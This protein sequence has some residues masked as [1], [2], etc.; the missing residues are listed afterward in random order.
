MWIISKIVC[1]S[2]KQKIRRRLSDCRRE[3]IARFVLPRFLFCVGS[4]L[5]G[6]QDLLL[7]TSTLVNG[8]RVTELNLRFYRQPYGPPYPIHRFPISMILS[9]RWATFRCFRCF[10]TRW[11]SVALLLLGCTL[12][13]RIR[14]S[15]MGTF[16][17]ALTRGQ[18]RLLIICCY[19]LSLYRFLVIYHTESINK[20]KYLQKSNIICV[21]FL[22][23]FNM[24]GQ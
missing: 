21:C 12:M 22:F 7:R 24:F 9:L 4:F 5:Y 20:L 2:T 18:C 3:Y 17:F 19:T 6:R 8:R 16:V 10:R 23:Q 11:I 14:T 1:A 13:L 15:L